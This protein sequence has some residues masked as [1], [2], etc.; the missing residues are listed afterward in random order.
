MDRWAGVPHIDETRL[1]ARCAG[2]PRPRPS[3]VTECPT[4]ADGSSHESSRL[5]LVARHTDDAI[6]IYGPDGR[7]DWVN[8]AFVRMS[9]YPAEEVKGARRT[10][11]VRGPFTRTPEF[12]RLAEDLAALRDA[13]LEFVTR[14]KDGAPYWVALQVRAA[15]QDG[16]VVGL[17]GVERD[18]TERRTAEERARRT[19][20]R[21]ESLGIALRHEKHLLAAVLGTIPHLVWWKNTDLRYIGANHAYL[22]FRGL[23][24]IAEVVGRLETQLDTPATMGDDVAALERSVVETREPVTDATVMLSAQDG[25]RRKF[26]VSVLPHV[27]GED[28]AGAIGIGTD[29]SRIT[30]LER[31]LAQSSRLE[32]IGQL[33]A[34]IAHEINTPV[35]YLSD[36]TRFVADAFGGVIDGLREIAG[37]VGDEQLD[38]DTLRG[39][40]GAVLDR[41]DL[42]FVGE[43][44]PHALASSLEGLE[45][46]GGIVR[47]MKD[48]SHPGQGRGEMDL[49]RIV[50]TTVEVTRSEWKYLAELSLDL[51]PQAGTVPAIE[52]EIKQVLLNLVVNAAQ[53]VAERRRRT[54]GGDGL[55]RIVIRTRRT[56]EFVTFTVEDDGVGMDESVREHAFDPFFTTKPVGQGTGQGLSL[57]HET[58]IR[59]HGGRIDVVSAPDQGA[60]FTVHLPLAVPE[61]LLHQD[62]LRQD[63]DHED[64]DHEDG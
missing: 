22:S 3:V 40:L 1:R 43:E 60:A 38:R 61:H 16:V 8:D 53:S 57:A 58:V 54:G 32:S 64:G 10:D 30:D 2:V 51:D 5:A 25:V 34:G 47:A 36:N 15:V 7:I 50:E 42:S 18:V 44:V 59:R 37:I 46:V 13:S 49:N 28:F 55:G 9:G 26:L 29:V 63:G 19:L 48:F 56:G 62:D 4:C 21:A 24:S 31:Q 52:G 12:T 45:R 41:L 17:V 11:L 27:E 39:R 33:A 23:G 14:T 35:Q 6:V 20:R